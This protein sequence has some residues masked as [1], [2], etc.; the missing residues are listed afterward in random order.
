MAGP[1]SRPCQPGGDVHPDGPD[2]ARGAVA[3]ELG[4]RFEGDDVGRQEDGLARGQQRGAVG[5]P[6]LV[7]QRVADVVAGRGQEGEGHAPADH[8]GVD[9]VQQRLEDAELVGHL[10]PADHG[11]ERPVRRAEQ[12]A[13]DLDL[14]SA[15]RKPGGARAAGSGGPTTEAWRRW[16]TPKASLT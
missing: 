10:G 3:A 13:Q 11:D 15:R 8:Q 1:M 5:D 7:D 9:P 12:A 16:D 2:L 14:A 4:A 6:V